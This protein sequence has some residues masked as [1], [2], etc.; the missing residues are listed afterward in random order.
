M[1]L[2]LFQLEYAVWNMWLIYMF[3]TVS[4]AP[5]AAAARRGFVCASCA[6]VATRICVWGDVLKYN[7][8]RKDAYSTG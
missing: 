8:T 3:P 1:K 7:I 6:Y 5:A 2:D 4:T